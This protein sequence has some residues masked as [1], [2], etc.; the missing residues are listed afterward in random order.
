MVLFFRFPVAGIGLM[1]LHS[2]TLSGPMDCQ[3]V[4]DTVCRPTSMVLRPQVFLKL[5]KDSTGYMLISLRTFPAQSDIIFLI[6]MF[7][8]WTV[9]LLPSFPH[10]YTF[11]TSRF[12]TWSYFMEIF[13]L[14]LQEAGMI[15]IAPGIF[16]L[17]VPERSG[18]V[19][20]P[21]YPS[22]SIS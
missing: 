17:S 12:S 6:F 15:L 20:S 14:I 16:L 8:L 5:L 9:L 10:M 13:S 2:I 18:K 4:L 22:S 11:R 7:M 3:M 21:F 19:C 1:S